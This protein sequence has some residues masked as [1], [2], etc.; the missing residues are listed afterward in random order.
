MLAV[1]KGYQALPN[2]TV[3]DIESWSDFKAA[4]RQLKTD[5][6]KAMFD[7]VTIDTISLLSDLCE[8]FICQ[9]EG[10]KS[11]A[12]IAYGGGYAFFTGEMNEALRELSMMGYGIVF[13]CHSDDRM[14]KDVYTN[15][16]IPDVKPALNKRTY[17][18]VNRLVDLICYIESVFDEDGIAVR[19]VHTRQTPSIFAG[20]RF[21]F[22]A[23]KFE[24]GYE[25]LAEELY[26]AIEMEGKVRGAK[27]VDSPDRV[28][29][30]N[31]RSFDEAMA[32]AK[33]IWEKLVS[34]DPGYVE[35]VGAIIEKIFGRPVKLSALNENQQELLELVIDEMKG[36]L[37]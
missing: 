7:T 35:K 2:A 19:T 5:E 34:L 12:D 21:R 33:T 28:S 3:Q 11:L 27:I 29:D 8:K 20:S 22:L 23:P 6:V 13:I 18:I 15:E 25:T 37:K 26:K 10:V 16:D 36:L 32:E 24:F 14:K 1:E 4:L 30:D 17:A 9:R 31:A